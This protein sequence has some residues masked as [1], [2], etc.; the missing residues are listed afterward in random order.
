MWRPGF[1]VMEGG[2][3]SFKIYTMAQTNCGW[4]QFWAEGFRAP[5]AHQSPPDP[6][7]VK[8]TQAKASRKEISFS[9]LGGC[10]VSVALNYLPWWRR[11]LETKAQGTHL[12]QVLDGHYQ[13]ITMDSKGKKLELPFSSHLF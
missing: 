4:T 13:V 8:P 2:G 6:V 10:A 5:C 1:G 7:Q 3:M 9:L 11:P 12:T